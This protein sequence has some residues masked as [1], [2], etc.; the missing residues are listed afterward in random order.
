MNALPVI[1]GRECIRALAK[2]GFISDDNAAVTSFCVENT[3]L[4]KL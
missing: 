3:L 2:V 1:S 4:H